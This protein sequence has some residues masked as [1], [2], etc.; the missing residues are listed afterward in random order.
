VSQKT[1]APWTGL[2]SSPTIDVL[3]L[4]EKQGGSYHPGWVSYDDTVA[5]SPDVEIL[6]GGVN[7][8]PSIGAALWRQ[9]NLFHFGF[10]LKPSD[11]NDVGRALL[12]DSIVYISKFRQERAICV[13]PSAFSG[14]ARSRGSAAKALDNEEYGIPRFKIA[15]G[16]GVLDGIPEDRAA[17]REWFVA[18]RAFLH[19][20]KYGLLEIDPDAHLLGLDYDLV[21][22]LDRAVEI[23]AEPA[24]D[25]AAKARTQAASRLLVRYVPE[26]PGAGADSAEWERWLEANR[27]YL[28]FSEWG[29]YRWYVDPLA[30]TRGVPTEK[31]HGPERADVEAPGETR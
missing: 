13:T 24:A 4:V 25:D 17:L 11:M 18:N 12:V 2:V 21:D 16:Q 31:L 23:L 15:F 10:D 27:P 7:E 19:P 5:D 3:P 1:P 6:S 26:G 30:K 29:G 9:G 28:F 8:K 14:G 22:S 20:G